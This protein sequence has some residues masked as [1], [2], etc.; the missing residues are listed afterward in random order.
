MI[1]A[2]AVAN[3]RITLGLMEGEETL[4]SASVASD[5]RKTAEEYAVL[6]GEVLALR[7]GTPRDAEGVIL[8]SVVPPLTETVSE[9]LRLLTGARV[10]VLGVGMKTGLDI[11]IEEPEQL[12]GDLVASAVG[13]AARYGA[14]TLVIDAGVAT[15]FSVLGEGGVYLGCAIAP[16]I[17]LSASALS[18]S[19]SLLPEVSGRLPSRAIGKTTA[20]SM[21]SGSVFGTVAML[22]GMISRL[23]R[24]LGT[25]FASVV[26]SGEAVRGLIPL[27]ERGIVY[28]GELLLR[29]LSLIYRRNTRKKA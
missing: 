19:A 7:G 25:P 8:T 20:E 1:L 17:A 11:R 22:D 18:A 23:E 27:C 2:A 12:G 29:G 15:S 24:E 3:E 9:A 14:P 16:G 6:F 5:A 10:R 13:A 21:R 26:A 4:A 28:D